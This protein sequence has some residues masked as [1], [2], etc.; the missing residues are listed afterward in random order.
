M[1][2]SISLTPK[3]SDAFAA[4]LPTPIALLIHEYV[5]ETQDFVKLH[6]LID[7]AE[8]VARFFFILMLSDLHQQMGVSVSRRLLYAQ[9]ERERLTQMRKAYGINQGEN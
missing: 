4:D 9:P 5:Q 1:M 8:M 7:A 6:R 3:N 2:T